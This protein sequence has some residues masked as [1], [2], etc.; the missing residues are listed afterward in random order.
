M[1]PDAAPPSLRWE[2]PNGPESAIAILLSNN[3]YRLGRA[4]GSGTRPRLDRGELGITVLAPVTASSDGS[5]RRKLAMQQWTATTFEI[6]S[7]G[8]VA[9]G[10]D[11]EAMHLEPPLRFRIRPG[12]L[13]VR[14]APQHPGVSPS[15]L[16]PDTPWQ[17]FQALARFALHGG[18]ADHAG[19]SVTASRSQQ[20]A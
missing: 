10:I 8:P 2:G 12:A 11:G 18:P 13:R 5:A 19:G 16:E 6:G 15:A 9:A 17:M 1:G 7:D 14:I 4:L 3:P 20:T